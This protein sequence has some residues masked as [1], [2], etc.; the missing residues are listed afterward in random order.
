M[1]SFTRWLVGGVIHSG[2]TIP[3]DL[4]RV[5]RLAIAD[6]ENMTVYPYG[7]TE[8]LRLAKKLTEQGFGD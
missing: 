4:L 7:V 3:E 8:T 6:E 1:F 5:V 2:E